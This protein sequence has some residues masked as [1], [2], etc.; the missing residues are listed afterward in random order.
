MV[1]TSIVVAPLKKDARK[2]KDVLREKPP[3]HLVPF[4]PST[5]NLTRV[6]TASITRKRRTVTQSGVAPP[7]PFQRNKVMYAIDVAV[8]P[9]S[10]LSCSQCCA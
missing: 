9:Y 7:R 2:L 4:P 8:L 5:P 10:V 1:E 6:H 3:K